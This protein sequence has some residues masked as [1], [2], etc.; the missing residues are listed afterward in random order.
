M[1][2]FT[3][4]LSQCH[5][6][7]AKTRFF[8]QLHQAIAIQ[9]QLSSMT[10]QGNTFYLQLN[11]ALIKL[12]QSINDFK[13]SRDLQKNEFMQQQARQQQQQPQQQPQQ[14]MQ[15]PSGYGGQPQ[16]QQPG[17]GFGGYGGYNPQGFQPQAQQP[18]QG[19][20]GYGGYNPMM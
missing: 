11:D 9:E 10:V 18:G 2:A 8:E 4:V 1:Q 6:D 15:Q 20:G 17:Q 3:A 12:Q 16:A 14:Q 5:A 19:F 13:M 7:P